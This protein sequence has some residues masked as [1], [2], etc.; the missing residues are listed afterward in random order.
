MHRRQV[1][2]TLAAAPLTLWAASS[3]AAPSKKVRA[4]AFVSLWKGN[5]AEV[6]FDVRLKSDG[7][8]LVRYR[9][10]RRRGKKTFPFSGKLRGK[11]SKSSRRLT[12]GSASFTFPPFDGDT[13]KWTGT[14]KAKPYIW[15]SG[16][17]F[18]FRFPSQDF[19]VPL[20]GFD[21]PLAGFDVPLAGYETSRA[22]ADVSV[23]VMQGSVKG[24]AVARTMSG[25]TT[26]T[27]TARVGSTRFGRK[28]MA[29]RARGSVTRR[30]SLSQPGVSFQG[31]FQSGYTGLS[32]QLRVKVGKSWQTSNLDF[33]QVLAGS[34]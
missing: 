31:T 5:G 16:Q 20:A 26:L 28:S 7:S 19:D 32:G 29:G 17:G 14:D 15:G 9:G 4:F 13:L 21:V 23:S 10:E 30:L 6:S 25:K 34:T 24:L 18:D 11:I 33:E 2:H 8:A 1:L 22:V 3:E 27:F 12:N